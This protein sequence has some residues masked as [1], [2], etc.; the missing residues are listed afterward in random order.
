M[1]KLPSGYSIYGTSN[2]GNTITAIKADSTA[3]K[4][5]LIIIDRSESAYN[6]QTG[7]FSIPNLRVR[8][9]V[10]T[11]DV[12]G[13]PKPERL[14]VDVNFRVPV[15]SEG[16]TADWFADFKSLINDAA[17]LDDAII[18]RF[19]PSCCDEVAEV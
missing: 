14:L 10:G 17:F 11:T 2:N 13:N 7:S 6:A 12:D 9:L 3:S 1:Y 5:K 8:V 18:H 15:G 16:D 4:P 19:F